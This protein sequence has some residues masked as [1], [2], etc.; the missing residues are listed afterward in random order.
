MI[1]FQVFLCIKNDFVSYCIKIF[2]SSIYFFKVFDDFLHFDFL[3][4]PHEEVSN[5]YRVQYI[6][7][8]SGGFSITLSLKNLL[9]PR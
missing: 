1:F 8:F 3:L 7:L 6:E 9:L 2:S 4:L 5:F